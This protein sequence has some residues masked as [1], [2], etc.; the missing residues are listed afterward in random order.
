MDA[1]VVA[2]RLI[3]EQFCGAR[4]AYLGGSA[5]RGTS[6]TTSDLDIVVVLDGAPA[7]YRKTVR[8]GGWPVELFVHDETSL[9]YW[10]EREAVSWRPVLAQMVATGVVLL[11]G[12]VASYLQDEAAAQLIAGPRPLT[13]EELSSRRYLLTDILDDLV[14]AVSEDE[15]DIIAGVVLT[16]S[17]ELFLLSQGSWLGAGKWLVR[18]LH[19]A[20]PQMA[21]R[22]MAA[23]RAAIITGE[24]AG[25]LAVSE[26][27]LDAVGG[28]LTEGYRAG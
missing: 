8:Y 1:L 15:R 26:D 4:A 17:A 19:G 25:L 7:P 18:N 5:S 9:Q 16:R 21:S 28:R 20:D 22:L 13:D 23:H 6:T 3:R 24:I 11:D 12:G 14:S 10:Y 2:R 27:I